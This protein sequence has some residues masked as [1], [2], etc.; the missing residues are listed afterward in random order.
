MCDMWK[1]R[2][3]TF[4]AKRVEF[5]T[6]TK[7]GKNAGKSNTGAKCLLFFDDE[8]TEKIRFHQDQFHFNCLLETIKIFKKFNI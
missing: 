3:E 1:E 5:K 8:V 4:G 6:S 2:F 7:G